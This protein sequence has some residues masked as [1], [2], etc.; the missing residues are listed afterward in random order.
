MNKLFCKTL[1]F[2]LTLLGGGLLRSHEA[3]AGDLAINEESTASPTP[4]LANPL[5]PK[6]SEKRS[7]LA[8]VTSVSQLSDV[9]PTDWAFGALQ[10]LVERYGCIEGYPDG[11]Y[12]GNRAMTRYEF[13]AGLNQ[14]LNRIQEL[15]ASLPQGVTKE[16]LATLQRLQE[17]F[18]SELASLRGRV[19]SLEARTAR[20]ETQQ[21]STT[22]KLSGQVSMY[23]GDVFGERAGSANN[24]T[25]G[26]QAFLTFLTSF[27]GKDSLIV[28]LEASN[29][30][31]FSTETRFPETDLRGTSDETRF[32]IPAKYVYGFGNNDI[33]LNQLQYRFPVGDKLTVSL[34]AFASNRVLSANITTLTDLGTGPISYFGKTSPL[35]YPINQQAG[36]GL[37]WRAA[38]WLNVDF[39]L[40]N[41][42]TANDPSKGLFQG[43]YAASVRPVITLGRLRLSAS[44]MNSYS[45]L[46]GID[47]AAGSNPAKIVGAGPVVAN[48]FF[49]GSFYRILPNVD[50]GGGLAHSK[51]RTLGEGTK[52]DAEVWQYDLDMVLYDVGKKGN[53]AGLI[54]GIQPRLGGTSNAALAQA[55]GLEPGQRSD[56]DVGYHIEVF[57]THRVNDNITIT[58]GVFWLT[59]PN[60]DER[61]PDVVVGVVRT[62]FSF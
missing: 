7:S 53:T 23:F 30:E 33:S 37:Q 18:A 20:L 55:I 11:T 36:I 32:V 22:T 61:N 45:P 28:G 39:S 9:Q 59:A 19:D 15:I 42:F 47:T 57:Y 3:I 38:P 41:E 40:A 52:G 26:Y 29:L 43:G 12:R 16:D 24:T 1:A 56:R 50:I 8:R 14:C 60:H 25:F 31:V 44:Y 6:S 34:D 4:G 5:A 27:S 54:F 10:S 46:F 21:F 35:L 58:P 13:A 2:T 17:E 48:T 51:V 62:S 49:V